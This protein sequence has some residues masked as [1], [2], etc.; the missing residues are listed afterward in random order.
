[1]GSRARA[2]RRE[3]RQAPPPV[4]SRSERLRRVRRL[5]LGQLPLFAVLVIVGL[6]AHFPTWL[7]VVFGVF[8]AV[9]VGNLLVMTIRIGRFERAE[10]AG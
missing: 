6:L 7:W 9:M 1:M 2:Q 3:R 10:R 5:S 8:L 4:P